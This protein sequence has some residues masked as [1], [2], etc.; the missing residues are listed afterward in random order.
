LYG[1]SDQTIKNLVPMSKEDLKARKRK[2]S[3][4]KD[5]L[6]LWFVDGVGEGHL[7][8][9]SEIY[10]LGLF[11]KWPWYMKHDRGIRSINE[12]RRRR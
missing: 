4:H 5:V 7:F 8:I 2:N 6:Q 1:L 12:T 9:T 3:R 10:R 11:L